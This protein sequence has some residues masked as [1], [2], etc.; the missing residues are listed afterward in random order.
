MSSESVPPLVEVTRK[1][2]Q[3]YR[4][5]DREVLVVAVTAAARDRSPFMNPGVEDQ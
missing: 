1:H 4:V 2:Y 3:I 5:V